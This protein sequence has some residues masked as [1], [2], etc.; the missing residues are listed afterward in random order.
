MRARWV[1]NA[2]FVQPPTVASTVVARWINSYFLVS[3]IGVCLA[4]SDTPLSA[5]RR[6]TNPDA[7]DSWVT[8]VFKCN[9]YGFC[10]PDTPLYSREYSDEEAAKHGHAEVV[11]VLRTG[12]H[13]AALFGKKSGQ[14]DHPSDSDSST[15]ASGTVPADPSDD[16]TH[17]VRS[18]RDG[19]QEKLTAAAKIYKS[20]PSNETLKE[21]QRQAFQLLQYDTALGVKDSNVIEVLEKILPRK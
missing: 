2:T 16:Q 19:A 9:K 21:V 7:R 6:Q 15:L 17:L 11:E 1:D 13:M 5:F 10:H 12:K 20:N 14:L 8:Q 3:T 18:L 4:G